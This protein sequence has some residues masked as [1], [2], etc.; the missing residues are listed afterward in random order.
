[1]LARALEVVMIFRL[2][3]DFGIVDAVHHSVGRS[4][5]VLEH[6]P[7]SLH[8]T[9]EH[10]SLHSQKPFAGAWVTNLGHGSKGKLVLPKPVKYEPD[11]NGKQ[12]VLAS[13]FDFREAEGCAQSP[14][15]LLGHAFSR[16]SQLLKGD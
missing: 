9:N 11:M 15:G 14:S 12:L 3:V 13:A 2:L 4:V 6:H 16:Y 10:A 8:A 7:K 5:N 1:M